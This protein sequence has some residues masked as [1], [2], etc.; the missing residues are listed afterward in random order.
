M[1]VDKKFNI[2]YDNI[3]YCTITIVYG[4]S[5]NIFTQISRYINWYQEYN[6]NST[7]TI[8]IESEDKIFELDLGKDKQKLDLNKQNILESKKIIYEYYSFGCNPESFP[9]SIKKKPKVYLSYNEPE[10]IDNLYKDKYIRKLFNNYNKITDIKLD[11]SFYSCTYEDIHS[12]SIALGISKIKYNGEKTAKYI[13]GYDK[14]L[15]DIED[16]K[17][18]IKNILVK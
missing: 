7:D 6:I 4:E 18:I 17:D 5:E 8:I 14:T 13:I 11:C 16:I 15:F 1:S 12:K 9:K 3:N 2:N 10:L